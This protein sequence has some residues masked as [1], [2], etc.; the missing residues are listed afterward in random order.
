[1]VGRIVQRRRRAASCVLFFGIHPTTI[2]THFLITT[3]DGFSRYIYLSYGT[4][5]IILFECGAL[6]LMYDTYYGCCV[7][8][9]VAFTW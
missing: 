4:S 5:G 6:V 9:S 8:V 3:G 7:V 1:M 2:I